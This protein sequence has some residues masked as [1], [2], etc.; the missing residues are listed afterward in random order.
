MKIKSNLKHS[1]HLEKESYLVEESK[2]RHMVVL[3]CSLG[4]NRFGVSQRVVEAAREYDW[5]KVF[6]Y[7]DPTYGDLKETIRDFWC[8]YADLKAEQ[9][10][11]GLGAAG[12]L[13]RLNRIFIEPGSKVLGYSPQWPDYANWVEARGG[14]YESSVL[15]TEESFRFH[16][17]RLV[18][19]I[20]D[21]YCLIFIDNPNNPTGQVINLEEIEEVI[22]QAR[23]KDVF[24][25]IDEAYGDYMEKENSAIGLINRYRN[26]AVVR[27]FSKGLGLAGMRV[28]YGIVPSGLN[29]YFN[30]IDIPLSVSSVS[31]Y[32]ARVALMDDDFV[33][34]CR[35]RVK[36]EKSKLI[37]GLK[38]RGYLISATYD[39]CP[40]FLVGHENGGINLREELLKKGILTVS[41]GC[42]RSLGSNYVR[43]NVPRRA[44]EFLDLL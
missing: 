21:E 32:L 38:E 10:Q 41:G 31:A 12:I 4:D 16:G 7:P 14:M 24:V 44:E 11:I 22:E 43:V 19:R 23:I 30:K 5:S 26:L 9:I 3:D 39:F 8:G 6:D 28:G 18:A 25:V 29:E 33:N 20:T 15:K 17:D 1:E 36:T 13:D 34:D 27:S 40:I 42:Y 35:R 2:I 37:E